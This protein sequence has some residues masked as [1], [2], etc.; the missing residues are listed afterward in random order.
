MSK[1]EQVFSE[2]GNVSESKIY[3][4]ACNGNAGDALI[5]LGF[6]TL[7][8]KYNINYISIDSNNVNLL[9]DNDVLIIAGGG[10]IVPEWKFTSEFIKKVKSNNS[11]IQM[12]ILPQS[13]RGVDELIST[14]PENTTIFCREK[15]S[16]DYCKE[17]SNVKKI[18]LDDDIALFCDIQKILSEEVIY[19]PK[20]NIKNMIRFVLF[21][22]HYFRSKIF[23]K[24]YAM[25]IDKEAN[26]N[27]S[28]KRTITN[29]FSLI[30]SFGAG[31]ERESLYS[32]K[33]LLQLVNFYEELHTDRLHVAISSYLLSKKLYI[34]NNGYYKCKG[35]YE[36]SLYNGKNITF[37]E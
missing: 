35:V 12:I 32:A 14:L 1:L 29:D 5:N 10:T 11:N 23:K 37:V 3:Y 7:A 26:H 30:A 21:Y 36:K 4:Y 15:Y 16:Y 9:K 17:K 22:Y 33:K 19:I 6:Y 24:V 13:I 34:Y 28:K 27:I 18:F 20:F 31:N 2:L 25:R 8:R